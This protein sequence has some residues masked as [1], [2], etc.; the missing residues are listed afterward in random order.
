MQNILFFLIT[1]V[2]QST[3]LSAKY[4]MHS[5][6]VVKMEV[7]NQWLNIGL[8][9]KGNEAFLYAPEACPPFVGKCFKPHPNGDYPEEMKVSLNGWRPI[10]GPD[11]MIVSDVP[12]RGLQF[13][14]VAGV[15]GA[16]RN[17]FFFESACLTLREQ[18]DGNL[19][20][21]VKDSDSPMTSPG[22]PW[23]FAAGADV[24]GVEFFLGSI[25]FDPSIEAIVL[26][27]RLVDL[28]S[29]KIEGSVV[30]ENSLLVPCDSEPRVEIF[31]SA[32]EHLDLENILSQRL[33]GDLCISRIQVGPY[34][35]IGRLLTRAVD[36]IIF[37]FPS[38]QMDFIP[39]KSKIF[40]PIK[41]SRW[42]VP[43]WS[44]P[45]P[46]GTSTIVFPT[47]VSGENHRNS[48][49]LYSESQNE[50]GCWEFL[51]VKGNGQFDLFTEPI[52][53]TDL[54][55]NIDAAGI[56]FRGREPTSDD[57]RWSFVFDTSKSGVLG[58]CPEMVSFNMQDLDI[59]EPE[60]LEKTLEDICAICQDH[61]CCNQTVQGLKG[62]P[63]K[64]HRKC[65]SRWFAKKREC[66][67]CKTVIGK[68]VSENNS[69]NC[70][71][72]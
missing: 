17:S 13:R 6:L 57:A 15:V 27:K 28:V 72:S 38:G 18:N 20:I 19:S 2:V 9:F 31:L 54:V 16:N 50:K 47:I 69:F 34:P 53:F 36:A 49:L 41:P 65:L 46:L 30:H 3:P 68:K 4:S 26:P 59:P 7:Q 63:H 39:S 25:L 64:F 66:P 37:D 67:C 48:F 29:L 44:G 14:E 51:A 5:G 61:F 1:G 55:V 33:V 60:I 70:C 24:N 40:Q 11:I 21:F 58:V 43:V 42:L 62:C 32:Q 22:G 35:V 56:F 12:S 23:T 10:G 8:D 71:I 52:E 45:F